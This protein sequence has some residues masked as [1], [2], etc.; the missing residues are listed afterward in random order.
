MQRELSNDEIGSLYVA[1]M[2]CEMGKNPD[3]FTT[4][5]AEIYDANEKRNTTKMILE[6]IGKRGPFLT[7][8]NFVSIARE[9]W[10]HVQKYV[11]EAVSK[12]FPHMFFTGLN[13]SIGMAPIVSDHVTNSLSRPLMIFDPMRARDTTESSPS[14]HLHGLKLEEV[15]IFVVAHELVHVEQKWRGDFKIRGDKCLWK[16]EVYDEEETLNLSYE[17]YIN[18][19]F[20]REANETARRVLESYRL[21]KQSAAQ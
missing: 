16:G 9:N 3:R 6:I 2:A 4:A 17:D 8:R 20:E 5:S 15:P 13:S 7:A 11:H 14:H 18:L 19:P 10:R 21:D 12:N 1:A